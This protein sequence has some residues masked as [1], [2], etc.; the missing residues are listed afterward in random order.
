MPLVTV[1]AR[2][3]LKIFRPS[4]GDVARGA[5][6]DIGARNANEKFSKILGHVPS[7]ASH[8]IGARYA[9]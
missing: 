4:L 6:H 7:A 1:L 5:S 2:D 9:F 3:G 8:D